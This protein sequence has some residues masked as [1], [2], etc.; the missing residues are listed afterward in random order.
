M[1]LELEFGTEGKMLK[2]VPARGGAPWYG[3]FSGP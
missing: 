2:F 1:K 3:L